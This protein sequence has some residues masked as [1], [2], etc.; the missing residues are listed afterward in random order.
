MSGIAIVVPLEALPSDV[1]LSPRDI[2]N[3]LKDGEKH[4]REAEQ[5]KGQYNTLVSQM[6]AAGNSLQL[7]LDEVDDP[8]HK[9]NALRNFATELKEAGGL[10]REMP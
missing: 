9:A 10:V 5:L 3:T 6:R 2:I 8:W 4:R 7:I 1:Q